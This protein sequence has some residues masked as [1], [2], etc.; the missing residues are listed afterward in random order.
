[1]NFIV[2]GRGTG[3]DGGREGGNKK[4]IF[5]VHDCINCKPQRTRYVICHVI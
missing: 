2:A 4:A 3:Y 1:M 5:S